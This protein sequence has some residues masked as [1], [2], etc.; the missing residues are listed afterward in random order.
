[1]LRVDYRGWVRHG[2]SVGRVRV[3]VGRLMTFPFFAMYS[4]RSP[5]GNRNGTPP[6]AAVRFDDRCVC[7]HERDVHKDG[8]GGCLGCHFTKPLAKCLFFKR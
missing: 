7:G 4:E 8:A 1:M 5:G 6:V 3:S 2:E